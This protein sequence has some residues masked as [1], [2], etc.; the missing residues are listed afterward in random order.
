[1]KSEIQ[2]SAVT[3]ARYAHG[4]DTTLAFGRT[5]RPDGAQG[6]GAKQ[7]IPL[8]TTPELEVGRN[9]PLLNSPSVWFGRNRIILGQGL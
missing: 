4:S 6:H 2:S 3:R 5:I 7:S 1:M 9:R 8:V